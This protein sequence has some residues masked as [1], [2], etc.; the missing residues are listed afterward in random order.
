MSRSS[1]GK[2]NEV[3]NIKVEKSV[4]SNHGLVKATARDLP[5]ILFI[6]VDALRTD[7]VANA[8]P[9]TEWLQRIAD[10]GSFFT[11]PGVVVVAGGHQHTTD[12]L[13]QLVWASMFSSA[14]Q[15]NSAVR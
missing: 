11:G 1:P 12:G 13:T 4:L 14:N 2:V 6:V 5:D 8:E 15:A 7:V 9:G 10:R 3:V